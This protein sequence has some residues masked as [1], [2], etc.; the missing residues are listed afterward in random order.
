MKVLRTDNGL[1]FCNIEFDKFCEGQGILRHRTVRYTPQQNRVAERMNR[2]LLEKVRCLLLTSE[3]PK[4]FW[5]EVLS[6]ATYLVN[7]SPSSAIDFKCPEEVWTNRKPSLTHLRVIGCEAYAH[8][9]NGKLDPRSAKCVL[10]GYQE[11]SKG[12]RLWERESANVKVIVSRDVIFNELVFPCKSTNNDVGTSET[13]DTEFNLA[14]GTQIEVELDTGQPDQNQPIQVQD[15]ELETDHDQAV[16]HE[17][18]QNPEKQ[19]EQQEE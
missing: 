9:P 15:P 11:G 3:M 17:D 8:K 4:S 6:T 2:T 16:E 12:Y 13:N 10:L 7:R 14:G 19:E 1:E 5:G 18:Q